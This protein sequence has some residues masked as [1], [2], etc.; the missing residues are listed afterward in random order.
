MINLNCPPILNK[1]RAS[2]CKH[3]SVLMGL[4]IGLAIVASEAFHAPAWLRLASVGLFNIPFVPTPGFL[5]FVWV[6]GTLVF[7]LVFEVLRKINADPIK[8][9]FAIND[10]RH[11]FGKAAN[12]ESQIL[13]MLAGVAIP[14][15]TYAIAASSTGAAKAVAW[16]GLLMLQ[17]G[18]IAAML[19]A[20]ARDPELDPTL[21]L[22]T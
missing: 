18:F 19:F 11:C 21:P 15:A 17:R 16:L 22:S 6:M 1:L 13:Q 10:F 14:I 7:W 9:Q 5:E 20:L 8:I 3:N 4:V 2:L 12:T